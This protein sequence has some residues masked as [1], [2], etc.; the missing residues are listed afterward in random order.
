MKNKIF[1]FVGASGTGKS[2]LLNYIQNEYGRDLECKELSARKFLIKGN[3]YDN[4]MTDEIQ[5]K[6]MYYYVETLY[7]YYIEIKEKENKGER[8]NLFLSRFIIDTLAYARVLN[9]SLQFEDQLLETIKYFKD[10]VIL[11]YTPA[12]FPIKDI[13]DDLRGNNEEIR[14]KTNEEIL[15]ILKETNMS[16]YTIQ[17]DLQN[18][19][20]ELD[21]VLQEN[22]V[23]K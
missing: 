13:K 11:L 17:G 2:T 6:I 14:Q 15:K 3:S 5:S 12:D 20:L 22:N 8:Y 9:H 18:R 23:F 19:Q 1:C 16:F 21:K 10:K 4:T 7:K